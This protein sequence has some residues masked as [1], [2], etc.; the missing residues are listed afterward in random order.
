MNVIV[1]QRNVYGNIKFYPVNDLAK[2]FAALMRQ[3]TFDSRNLYD[4]KNLGV[5]VIID[6]KTIN[7]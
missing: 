2:L 3:K 4:I 1:E 5:T 7:I 6:Q